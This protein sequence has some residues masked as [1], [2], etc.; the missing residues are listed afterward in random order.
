MVSYLLEAGYCGWSFS[1]CLVLQ[2]FG[3]RL[4]C[5]LITAALPVG[6]FQCLAGHRWGQVLLGMSEV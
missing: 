6:K 3:S 1:F 5:A 4:S 2:L